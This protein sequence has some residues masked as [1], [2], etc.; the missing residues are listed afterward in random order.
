MIVMKFGGASLKDA[1]AINRTREIIASRIDKN[2]VVVVSAFGGIT[3][4]LYELTDAMLSRRTDKARGKVSLI[5][6]YCRRLMDETLSNKLSRG[7]AEVIIDENISRLKKLIS[8][9]EAVEEVSARSRDM[10]L[11]SGELISAPL[12]TLVL[13]CNGIGCEYVD[14]RELILTDSEHGAANPSL[15]EIKERCQQRL[16]PVVVGGTVPVVGGFVGCSPD[17]ALTTLG[18]GGSDLTASVIALSIG[19]DSLEFWKDVDG[20]LAADPRI[21]PRARPVRRITFQEA[22]E[23]AFLGAKVLHPASIQPAVEAGIPVKVLNFNR[24]SSPGTM[25]L[26]SMDAVPGS[27]EQSPPISSIAYKRNQLMVN[28]FST[29]MLGARG[30]L[31]RVF[32]VFDRIGLSVDH[33]ATS[34]VNV[35]VTLSATDRIRELEKELNEVAVVR[36]EEGVG[37]VSVVGRNLPHTPGVARRIFSALADFNIKL[38]TYG[39]SGV[40]LSMVVAD[41]D[42]TGAVRVLHEELIPETGGEDA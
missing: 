22:A 17:G 32:E 19:A 30:F 29:R 15:G 11:G 18:R 26:E 24:P 16:V 21:V 7:K 5:Y 37:I 10:I 40:N 31:R 4:M 23:L 38:I 34:E 13:S 41:G 9:I 3:D 36:V 2:P 6:E 20:I 8:G 28:V 12:I 27:I 39:G 35:T 14:P 33:I 42:V 1:E 25:I